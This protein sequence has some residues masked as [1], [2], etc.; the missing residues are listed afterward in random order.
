MTAVKIDHS[1]ATAAG[2]A[3]A[4]RF[5]SRCGAPAAEPPHD[6]EPFRRRRVCAACGM[7]MLLSCARES[8]PGAGAAF[9]IATVDAT[10]SAVSEAAELLFGPEQAILGVRVG[11]L[12]GSPI[13]RDRL[14]QAVTQAAIR[15][16]EPEIVPVRGL[17]PNAERLGMMVAR[18]STCG[19]PRAALITVEPGSLARR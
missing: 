17:M 5:C 4:V 8:L 2:R 6:Q 9:V 1:F 12:L 15:A 14:L 18:I 3:N 11:D 10:V 19:R 13:E 7:G 16:R